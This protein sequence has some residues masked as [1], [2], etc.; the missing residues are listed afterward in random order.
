[1]NINNNLASTLVKDQFQDSTNMISSDI[2]YA[3]LEK[4]PNISSIALANKSIASNTFKKE[5]SKCAL[6]GVELDSISYKNVKFL[7]K[8]I[9]GRGKIVS[10]RISGV[11]K[12]N[13]QRALRLAII[14]ARFLGLLPYVKY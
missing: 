12:K 11:K 4:V 5:T 6:E 3:D 9:S 7:K 10:C 14:R 1:M 8:Y 13:K 2:S